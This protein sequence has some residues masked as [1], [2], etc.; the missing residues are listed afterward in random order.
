MPIR[1]ATQQWPKCNYRVRYAESRESIFRLPGWHKHRHRLW[2]VD[3]GP[4]NGM[5]RVNGM[6]YRRTNASVGVYAPGTVY[7]EN[8]EVGRLVSWAWLLIEENGEPSLLENLTGDAG[9]CFLE[10]PAQAV[11]KAI[12][13]LVGAANDPLPGR[14][15]RLDALLNH[16]LSTLFTLHSTDSRSEA[17]R[18]M[19]KTWIHPWRQITWSLLDQSPTGTLS[20][21][22]L[23]SEL[24]VSTST[25]THQYRGLCGE[26]LQET[27]DQWRIEKACV[28]LSQKELSIKQISVMV[29]LSYQ[30]YLSALFKAA[31]SYSPSEYRKRASL[32]PALRSES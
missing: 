32:Q 13:E 10:D 8:M 17:K 5:V 7:E 18:S 15:F 27:L 6:V 11:R 23:A 31:T 20:V 3:V 9:F 26:S 30:S 2:T 29:G 21:K 16:I 1:I 28:L 14:F 4:L 24:G 25:L 22:Q 12:V 19:K